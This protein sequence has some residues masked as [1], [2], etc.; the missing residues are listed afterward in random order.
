MQ[1]HDNPNIASALGEMAQSMPDDT[2]IYYPKHRTP[3]GTWR[4]EEMT[5]AELDDYS[6]DI[7]AGLHEIGI[8]PGT[9][10]VLMVEPS[11]EFFALTFALFKAA[12]VPV[13]VDPGMGLSNLKTCLEEAEPTAFIG[14]SKAQLARVVLRW[15]SS[16]I[17][18][19]VTVGRRWLWGGHK[20]EQVRQKGADVDAFQ[21][22][23]VE[24]SDMAAILF[25]SGS[26]GV[27]KGAVYNHGNFTAQVDQ[28]RTTYDIEPGEIDLPT[29][30]LFALFDPA[31]GMTT[32]L[33]KM[34][35]ANPGTVNPRNLVEPIEQFGIT[36]MFGSPAVMDKL[37]RYVTEND[38][39]LPSL[40]RVISAGAPVPSQTLRR[41]SSML[42]GD[43]E[44][45]TPYGATE[46][47][48]V[49]SIGSREILEETAD[50]TDRGDGVCVG[51]PV[52][53]ID[54]EVIDI[55]DEPIESWSDDL[56]A[57]D[58]AVGEFVV[59]GPQ[60]TERYYN[61]PEATKEA[62][63]EDGKGLR[64]RMGDVGYI[65][66]A[67]RMW[68]CGRKSHRVVVDDDTTMFTICCEA[69]FNTHPRVYRTALVGVRRAGAVT[70][71]LCVELE[72][73][74]RGAVRERMRDE[75]RDIATQFD[76]TE[77]IDTFLFHDSFPVDVRHNSKIFREE[78]TQW[79]TTN[80]K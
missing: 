41:V 77:S 13:M 14:V 48:P 60:V 69:V 74:H 8:T 50:K 40:K 68:F 76:H 29:F 30:P 36:N 24:A 23:G 53:A 34:D 11:M 43:A 70:P 27:P 37:G 71:V 16:T 32:V 15:G 19:R 62:K 73:E 12:V 21:A 7:A 56:I 44:I 46:S 2:A 22:P 64:H 57:A 9:R 47:L 39:A 20:L 55:V 4:Y 58:G 38:T 35:F 17:E 31:L 75:L 66:D 63:I 1:S 54:V 25:T 45:H 42:D 26:T 59:N 5:Y 6:T 10:A 51:R 78:L 28:I 72:E 49:A 52:D 33:P 3:D 18:H 65:D 79:A 61:R 80:L 67:G